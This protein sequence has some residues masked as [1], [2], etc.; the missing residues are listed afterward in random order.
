LSFQFCI[1]QLLT[2]A[3]HIHTHDD[4]EAPQVTP[5]REKAAGCVP[6]QA[7]A[8]SSIVC[9][10]GYIPSARRRRECGGKTAHDSE[11]LLPKAWQRLHCE[12]I[13]MPAE[14]QRMR[15]E[16]QRHFGSPPPSESEWSMRRR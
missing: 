14:M 4:D 5:V 15:R 9:I 8:H 13:R 11:F 7:I 6:C 16:K 3:Q 10:A 1:A 12:S 2:D